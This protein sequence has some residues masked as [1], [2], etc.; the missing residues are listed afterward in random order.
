MLLPNPAARS[1][2]TPG[3]NML[4]SSA[5]TNSVVGRREMML[6]AVTGWGQEEDRRRSKDAGFDVH[7]TKP[8]DSAVLLKHL[9]QYAAKVAGLESSG[10]VSS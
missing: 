3:E 4:G 8:V 7:L 2:E 5:D 10:Q 9:Q 6:I 1:A